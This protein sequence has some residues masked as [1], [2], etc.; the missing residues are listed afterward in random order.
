MLENHS[1]QRQMRREAQ[2][3]TRLKATRQG[4]LAKNEAHK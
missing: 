1:R 4:L 3:L 2:K